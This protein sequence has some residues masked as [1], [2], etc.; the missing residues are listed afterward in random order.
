MSTSTQ[1]TR[2]SF[3]KAGAMVAAPVAAVGI[4]AAVAADDGSK[5]ALARLQ[6]ERA[7]EALGRDFV[8]A[9]NRGGVQGAAGLFAG[10]A[11]PAIASDVTRLEFDMDEGLQ[12]LELAD[13]GASATARYAC[14]VETSA[15][16]EGEGTL[17]QMARLQGNAAVTQQS[18]Q[19]LSAR[20]ARHADGWRLASVTLG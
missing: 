6:D 1:T 18:R 3:L 5:A 10:R 16:L 14:T 11:A 7:I 20:Y 2:R 8:R 15:A 4:P 13:D 9:F 19:T 12:G 17:V